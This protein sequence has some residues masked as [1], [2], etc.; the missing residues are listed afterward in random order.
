MML[1]CTTPNSGIFGSDEYGSWLV[2]PPMKN[3]KV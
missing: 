1:I 2:P 3:W